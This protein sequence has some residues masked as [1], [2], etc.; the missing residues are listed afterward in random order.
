M[1]GCGDGLVGV[2]V[3]QSIDHKA[4]DASRAPINKR[5]Y[6]WCGVCVCLGVMGWWVCA[7]VCMVV[8]VVVVHV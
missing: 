5:M 6:V 4:L 3:C 8:V 1:R 2:C 7:C